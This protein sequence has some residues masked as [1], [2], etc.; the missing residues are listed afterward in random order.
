MPSDTR[1]SLAGSGVAGLDDILRGGLPRGHVY[2]VE[3]DPGVGKTTLSLQFLLEGRRAGE[4]TIYVTLSETKAELETVAASHGWSLDGIEI[5]E[6]TPPEALGDEQNTLFHPSEVEL[7]ETTRAILNACGRIKPDR[8]VFDSLSEIRLLAQT[9]LRYRREVLALKQYFAGRSCTV[10]LLDDRTSPG[11]DNH[12]QSIAHGVISLE[13]LAPL[14]GSQRRRLRLAKVRGVDFRGGFHDF[15]IERGGLVV[16]PRLVAAQHTAP[17]VDGIA[18]SGV[19]GLD[20]ML[21]GGLHRGTS[22]LLLGPAGTG[23]SSISTQWAAAAAARGEVAAIFAFD[24]TIAT[25]RARCQSIGIDPDVRGGDGRIITRQID[26]AE[27][28]PGQFAYQ[29]RRAVE[30]DGVRLVVIDSLNGYMNA[31]PDES[32]LILQLHELLTYLGQQGVVTILVVAQH[33]LVGS[34]VSPTDI[35]YLADTV[36]MLR[37]FEAD[38][39]LRRAL[40]VLKRRTGKHES[41]IREFRLSDNGV[42]VGEPLS[43]FRGVLTGVP[44]YQGPASALLEKS[45]RDGVA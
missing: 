6:L 16:F 4:R 12:L 41:A 7:A 29:V 32:F 37:H 8:A 39:A 38:G 35:S 11:T 45:A 42:V 19:S 14:Y 40:S 44:T 18:A 33:G 43:R 34:M 20:A 27:V 13:Q 28:P 3:G 17:V 5:F 15:S 10:L 2:L 26:P 21:D 22:T 23:K 36:I 24:E 30:H 25:F 31:M 9:S 1:P